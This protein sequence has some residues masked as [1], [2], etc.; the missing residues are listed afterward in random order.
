MLSPLSLPGHL[1][2]LFPCACRGAQAAGGG[3]RRGGE[4]GKGLLWLPPA[5]HPPL[6]GEGARRRGAA[7]HWRVLPAVCPDGVQ[8]G[9]ARVHPGHRGAA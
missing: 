7:R 1:V 2:P 9:E 5:P 4:A 8:R 6:S 3:G